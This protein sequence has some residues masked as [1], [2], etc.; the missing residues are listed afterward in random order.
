MRMKI[1]CIIVVSFERKEF[2][3]SIHDPIVIDTAF[4]VNLE[5]KQENIYWRL[6]NIIHNHKWFV[7]CLNIYLYN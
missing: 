7:V 6:F 4:D 2:D 5:S 1:N 3:L